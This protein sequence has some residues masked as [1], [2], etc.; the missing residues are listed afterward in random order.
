MFF[1]P[2]DFDLGFAFAGSIEPP[3]VEK[4]ELEAHENPNMF[5][6]AVGIISAIAPIFGSLFAPD[7]PS[8]APAPAAPAPAPAPEAPTV[9]TANDISEEPV[10]DTEAAR[11]RAQKRRKAASD[12]KLFSL[13]SDDSDST[14]LS[15]SLLGE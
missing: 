8:P 7:P 14:I 5:E 6:G 1:N 9:S 10:V 15:K 3:K 13:S 11:V 4:Q 2:F 12:Q